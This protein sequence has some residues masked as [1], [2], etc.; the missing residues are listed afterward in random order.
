M[1]GQIAVV[2]YPADAIDVAPFK[3]DYSYPREAL[4]EVMLLPKA[5][6]KIRPDRLLPRREEGRHRL[7]GALGRHFLGAA[8]L[9]DDPERTRTGRPSSGEAALFAPLPPPCV[10][11]P[12]AVGLVAGAIAAAVVHAPEQQA[13]AGGLHE[14]AAEGL[15]VA[16]TPSSLDREG[17]AEVVFVASNFVKTAVRRN[18]V[19]AS[20]EMTDPSLKQGFTRREWATGEHPRRALSGGRDPAAAGRLVVPQ[21]R[22]ARHRARADG[23]QP[24][25]AEVVHDRAEA[26]RQPPPTITGSSPRGRRTAS[27]RRRCSPTR[28]RIQGPI[29]ESDLTLEPLAAPAAR[30]SCSGCSSCCPSF[31]AVRERVRGARAERAHRRSTRT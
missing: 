17:R 4:L 31:L 23:R 9:A 30:C 7:E 18:H 24:P 16:A 8:R 2:P 6:A 21:R 19:D 15:Q 5:T 11:A 22:R 26:L 20:W 1:T 29:P 12:A 10:L 28:P 14:G 3:I 25:A 27:R 13:G